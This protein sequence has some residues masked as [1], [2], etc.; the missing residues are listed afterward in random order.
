MSKTQGQNLLDAEVLER[1]RQALLRLDS[2][3][4]RKIAECEVFH[5]NALEQITRHFEYVV[6]LNAERRR[7]KREA[8]PYWLA[9]NKTRS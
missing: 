9:E 6:S 5:M 4:M 2:D 1:L 7:E 3:D 8:N